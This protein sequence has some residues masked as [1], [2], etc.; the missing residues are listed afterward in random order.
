MYTAYISYFPSETHIFDQVNQSCPM[1]LHIF[2]FWRHFSI[3]I[4]RLQICK[5]RKK[6]KIIPEM[7]RI[8]SSCT[9]GLKYQR[10]IISYNFF[11]KKYFI[12]MKQNTRIDLHHVGFNLSSFKTFMWFGQSISLTPKFC[13]QSILMNVWLIL[14][15]NVC[16]IKKSC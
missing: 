5:D 8:I 11:K 16:K 4:S 15:Y 7:I 12:N 9:V 3:F 6:I 10:K 1:C 14:F 2:T 13:K